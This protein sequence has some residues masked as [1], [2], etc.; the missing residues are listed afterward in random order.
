MAFVNLSTSVAHN[1]LNLLPAFPIG[2]VLSFFGDSRLAYLLTVVNV[3][4]S[5]LLLAL[6]IAARRLGP[7]DLGMGWSR[8]A[9]V[10]T[11]LLGFSLW[12]PVVLGY[13]DLGGVAIALA[14]L[15]LYL[16]RE[17]EE[18]TPFHAV[19][20]GF[21]TAL[22]FLFRRW[23]GFWSLAFCL[24]VAAEAAVE[25]ALGRWKP[26]RSA[27]WIGAVAAG[28]LASVALPAVLQ[29][30]A[31]DFADKFTAFKVRH[32]VAAEL[33]APVSRFGL[34]LV[35]PA[36]AG[37]ALLAAGPRA[38]RRLASF[39]ALQIA[40]IFVLMRRI[41]D[42]DIHHFYLYVP[43][44]LCVVV[45]AVEQALV[46]L[47]ADRSRL[48]LLGTLF[49]CGVTVA[50]AVLSPPVASALHP[51]GPSPVAPKVRSDL[52]EV[53]RLLGY[54]DDRLREKPGYIYVFSSGGV[55]SDQTL[56][57]A[58]LSAGVSY[59]SPAVVLQSS[60][61][62]RRDG[63]PCLLLKADYAVLPWPIDP[64]SRREEVQVILIPAESIARRRD[65]GQAFRQLPETFHLE[66]RQT[67]LVYR[68][69]RDLLPPEVEALS[70]LLRKTYP[71]RP[72]IYEP[73][74]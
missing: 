11:M 61:L 39:V 45:V 63:F 13:L 27:L 2:V 25:A 40:L 49:A 37:G 66:N 52:P 29:V 23:Y 41:Q 24:L 67:V 1:T 44:I 47:P 30:A 31:T 26:L 65:I 33:S 5:L 20:I 21:L 73:C 12:Q 58:N 59:R 64:P 62:D 10:A 32:G 9:I 36:L 43:G 6:V 17:P 54:L 42:P 51:W 60:Q 55:I 4:G 53:L 50:T 19:V 56:A 57:F 74:S 38:Q 34:L 69:E 68:R 18:L 14:I 22:L 48:V 71:G 8:A 16:S 46:R 72:D 3:Y 7:R 28:T 15:T 70:R 35:I